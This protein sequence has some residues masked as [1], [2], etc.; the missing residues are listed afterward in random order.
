MVARHHHFQAGFRFTVKL[1]DGTHKRIRSS[2]ARN[3]PSPC[4]EKSALVV[5]PDVACSSIGHGD[6]HRIQMGVRD[7]D[8][9]LFEVCTHGA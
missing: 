9:P 6:S 1:A 5:P 7:E 4:V 3:V 2:C 8:G